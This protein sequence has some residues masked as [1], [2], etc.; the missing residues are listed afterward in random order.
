MPM[1]Q[2][3][4]V[5]CRC[6]DHYEGFASKDA[7]KNFPPDL[8]IEPRHLT[9]DVF[10]DVAG[11]ALEG[12]AVLGVDGANHGVERGDARAHDLVVDGGRRDL[13]GPQRHRQLAEEE[14]VRAHAR[15]PAG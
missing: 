1:Y 12:G 9:I 3:K 8:Q 6:R 7:P 4:I 5:G 14:A 15:P 10:V 2:D 11:R 13:P